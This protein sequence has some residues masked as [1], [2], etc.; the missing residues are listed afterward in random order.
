MQT[1][2]AGVVM[3]NTT[4]NNLRLFDGVTVGGHQIP[5]MND[6][7]NFVD[8]SVLGSIKELET[9]GFIWQFADGTSIPVVIPSP[10]HLTV[11]SGTV[12]GQPVLVLDTQNVVPDS[13]AITAG[14]GLTGGGNLTENRTLSV[15]SSVVRRNN[16]ALWPPSPT[17]LRSI[18]GAGNLGVYEHAAPSLMKSDMFLN[19]FDR[20]SINIV[21]PNAALDSGFYTID[22]AAPGAAGT[23][24]FSSRYQVHVLTTASLVKQLAYSGNNNWGAVRRGTRVS[25]SVSWG[26][27]EYTP[28]PSVTKMVLSEQEAT[29]SSVLTTTVLIP[30]DDT[31]PQITEGRELLTNT[32]PTFFASSTIEVTLSVPVFAC[33]VAGTMTFALFNGAA[34]AFAAGA[35]Y[36]PVANGAGSIT[37]TGRFPSPGDGSSAVVSARFGAN[38]AGT[39][40]V[41]GAAGAR[42]YGGVAVSRLLVKELNG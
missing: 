39:T 32:F 20:F 38:V 42:R 21:N 26:N 29:T 10:S 41:N 40:T 30:H 18:P 22:P 5:N 6:V 3:V 31:I 35:F 36:I 14:V 33:S 7:A 37:L 17:Y 9:P 27:W 28:P 23:H 15:D 16:P 12:D 24:P 25:D 19:G 13:R 1:L 11:S 4:N 8:S 34:N 2:Q